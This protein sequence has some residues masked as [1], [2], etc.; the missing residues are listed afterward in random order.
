MMS[1]ALLPNAA[2]LLLLLPQAATACTSVLVTT[3]SDGTV[4][5]RTMELGIPRGPSEM[6]KIYTY[7]RGRP[8]P[9]SHGTLNASQYGFIAFQFAVENFTLDV[10]TTEGIN[11]LGLTVSVQ[12]HTFASYE[13]PNASKHAAIGDLSVASFLLGCC[14]D[15]D[16]AAA[17]LRSINVVPTPAVG[18]TAL[19]QVHWSVQDASGQS[20]V[21]EYIDGALR[22]YDNTEVGV[23][24]NDPGY[25]WQLGNLNQYSGYAPSATLARF[26]YT[27]TSTGPFSSVSVPPSSGSSSSGGGGGGSKTARTTHVPVDSSHGIHSKLLPGGYTPPD[28]FVKSFLL[29]QLSIHHKPPK[30]LSEGLV[31]T[32]GLINTVHIPY[33]AVA[34]P[35]E[36]GLMEFTNWA[37][38][39]APKSKL[40]YYRTYENMQWRLIDLT[41]LDFSGKVKYPPIPLSQGSFAS[42]VLDA[43]PTSSGKDANLGAH[44]AF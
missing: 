12:T 16:E 2:M 38:M 1:I 29:K 22:V 15:V 35:W 23:L 4:I 33:G 8:V 21:F 25:E 24:T 27:A 28:R 17:K 37:V 7:P 9:T 18:R 14:A 30:D 11:E 13:L 19:G 6:E 32:Q 43:T 41:R 26:P 31:L 39:K 44:A 36:A 40:L 10:G 20:R 42:G 5:G 34:G 3:Q